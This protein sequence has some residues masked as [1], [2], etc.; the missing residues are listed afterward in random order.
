M[1]LVIEEKLEY[2]QTTVL[3]L[4]FAANIVCVQTSL[5]HTSQLVG[6]RSCQNPKSSPDTLISGLQ[7]CFLNLTLTLD[8][9]TL[10][11]PLLKIG[12]VH[13]EYYAVREGYR[14]VIFVN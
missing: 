8:L 11:H 7:C 9:R 3:V 5:V 4:H 13:G 6:E 12:T 2:Y 1:S 10:N 14:L